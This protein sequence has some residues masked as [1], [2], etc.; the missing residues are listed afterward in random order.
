V[1]LRVMVVDDFPDAA[2]ITQVLLEARGY[3]VRIA[4]S[5]SEALEVADE[6]DPDVVL[7]DLGLPDVSGFEIARV[8]RSRNPAR[9]LYLAAVTGWSDDATRAQTAAAGFDA[10]LVKP[11]DRNKLDGVMREAA[12]GHAV[13]RERDHGD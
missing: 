12:L 4:L 6:F 5:G 10:H 2:S 8:M 9:R 1:S 3:D 7:L 13:D 11:T